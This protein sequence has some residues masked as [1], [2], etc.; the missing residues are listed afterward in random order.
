MPSGLEAALDCSAVEF[1]RK[2]ALVLLRIVNIRNSKWY[3]MEGSSLQKRGVGLKSIVPIHLLKGWTVH[4]VYH[5]M[6]SQMFH[7]ILNS[8]IRLENSKVSL[9]LGSRPTKQ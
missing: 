7:R 6:N 8:E 2:E 3:S 5:L 9:E 1:L 4:E